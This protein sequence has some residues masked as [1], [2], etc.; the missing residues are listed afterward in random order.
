MRG[1]SLN[2]TTHRLVSLNESFLYIIML[3]EQTMSSGKHTHTH[4]A[5]IYNKFNNNNVM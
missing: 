3:F 2:T 5:Y 1:C 4:R